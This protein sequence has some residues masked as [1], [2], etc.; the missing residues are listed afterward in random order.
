MKNLLLSICILF[1]SF[2]YAQLS[3]D[4]GIGYDLSTHKMIATI[5]GGYEFHHV[6]IEGQLTPSM[7]RC[8][9]V[10]NLFGIKGGYSIGPVTPSIGYYY[11]YRSSDKTYLNCGDLGYSVKIHI[12]VIE[13]GSGV[14]LNGLYM[15]QQAQITVGIHAVL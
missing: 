5:V 10:N 3:T 8:A 4:W 11:N 12:R 9:G 15:R 13:N 2:S 6:V 1:T 14:Y 7:T